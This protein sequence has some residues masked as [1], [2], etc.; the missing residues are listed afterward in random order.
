MACHERRVIGIVGSP[1]RGKNTA[2][3][4]QKVLE[5]ARSAGLETE[6]L[7]ISDYRINPCDACNACIRTGQCAQ[8]DD[9]HLFH[10]ALRRARALVLGTPIYFDHVSAQIKALLDR[11]YPYTGPNPAFRFPQGVKAVLVA[12][13]EDSNPTAY[14]DVIDWLEGRLSHYFGV[15]T[16]GILKGSGTGNTPVSRREAL[17]QEAF[18]AGARLA[19]LLNWKPD[20]A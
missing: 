10:A 3:L 20:Q 1:R 18:D 9:M 7:Y 13:W 8:D 4:V 5:G 2:T 17:L 19:G 6:L 16:V 15:E 12:T 11:L 14:D